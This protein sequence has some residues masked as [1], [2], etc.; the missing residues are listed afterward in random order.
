MINSTMIQAWYDELQ[1]ISSVEKVALPR[2]RRELLEGT[3]SRASKKEIEPLLKAFRGRSMSGLAKG[4]KN[5]LEEGGTPFYRSGFDIPGAVRKIVK[6]KKPI[7]E[8]V[9]P[10]LAT[11]GGGGMSVPGLGVAV[12]PG[13]TAFH[14]GVPKEYHKTLDKLVARHEADEARG[15]LSAVEKGVFTPSRKARGPLEQYVTLV[16]KSIAPYTKTMT[17]PE[18]LTRA[19][20]GIGRMSKSVA[21]RLPE[22]KIR[23][24]VGAVSKTLSGPEVPEGIKA[25]TEQ[26]RQLPQVRQALLATKG[27][28]QTGQHVDPLVLIRESQHASLA[29]KTVREAMRR[30]RES[31]GEAALFRRAGWEYGKSTPTRAKDIAKLRDA[32]RKATESYY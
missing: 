3:L 5:I 20:R 9:A 29:P 31:T 12:G 23:H 22:G 15:A 8:L 13:A 26:M 30:A 18:T 16:G 17:S 32:M 11:L 6:G 1:K 10:G 7:K 14:K 2:W 21:K 24:G 27:R 28:I 19:A 25:F 4:T